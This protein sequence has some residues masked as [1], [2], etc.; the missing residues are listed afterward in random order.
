[1]R[2]IINRPSKK[3]DHYLHSLKIKFFTQLV[4]WL[5]GTVGGPILEFFKKNGFSIALSI[6]VSF[7]FLKL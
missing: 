7:F 3:N 5:G 4:A 2:L 6:L 1:M